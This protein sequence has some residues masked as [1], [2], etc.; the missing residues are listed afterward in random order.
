MTNT[1]DTTTAKK[2]IMTAARHLSVTR[3]AWVA[4]GWTCGIDWS[5][6]PKGRIAEALAT[7]RYIHQFKAEP[8]TEDALTR[9]CLRLRMAENTRGET[10]L[11]AEDAPAVL[12]KIATL[13]AAAKKLERALALHKSGKRI[14]YKVENDYNRAIREAVRLEDALKKVGR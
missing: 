4:N 3:M 14:N 7:R 13:R 9:L 12:A 5:G 11:R 10:G 1:T 2:A 6:S 8:I